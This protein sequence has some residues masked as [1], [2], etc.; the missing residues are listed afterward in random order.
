MSYDD[1]IISDVIYVNFSF[2]LHSYCECLPIKNHYTCPPSPFTHTQK[3]LFAAMLYV[4]S[5]WWAKI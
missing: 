5:F 3:K 1:S 4:R 2:I